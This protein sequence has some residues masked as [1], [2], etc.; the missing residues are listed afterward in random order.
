M[1]K[2]GKAP[3]AVYRRGLR[4]S[5]R[6]IEVYRDILGRDHY[7]RPDG[8]ISNLIDEKLSELTPK[9]TVTDVNHADAITTVFELEAP[10]GVRFAVVRDHCVVTMLTQANVERN[11]LGNWVPATPDDPDERPPARAAAATPRPL[12]AVPPVPAPAPPPPA[13]PAPPIAPLPDRDD[14][15][16]DLSADQV[17]AAFVIVAA[18]LDIARAEL[19]LAAAQ[20]DAD[21]ARTRM[22]IEAVAIAAATARR[23]EALTAL[24]AVSK[25]E[26][27]A[28]SVSVAA[29]PKQPRPP[30]FR[31]TA[32]P[33]LWIRPPQRP[34]G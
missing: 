14:V 8:D 12:A 24:R 31:S 11:L 9:M 16:T 1:G 27:L 22:E 6:A 15:L 21:A 30:T 28:A 5:R 2:A 34:R 3:R 29:A 17:R 25:H 33:E 20:R 13:A 10:G 19:R 4:I 26:L 18:E 23:E 7:A 32:S